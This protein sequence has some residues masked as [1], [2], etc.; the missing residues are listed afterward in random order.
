MANRLGPFLTLFLLLYFI[1]FFD[2]KTLW[3]W[4]FRDIE[5]TWDRKI[6]AWL[7]TIHHSDLLLWYCLFCTQILSVESVIEILRHGKINRL[8]KSIR[9]HRSYVAGEGGEIWI[10]LCSILARNTENL[11]LGWQQTSSY[12]RPEIKNDF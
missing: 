4:W 12:N 9:F 10:V 5:C 6:R 7:E 8:F 1:D 3:M 11:S 2:L